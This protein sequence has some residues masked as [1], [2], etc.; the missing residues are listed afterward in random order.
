T[1]FS[2]AVDGNGRDALFAYPGGLAVDGSGNLYIADHNNHTI[3]KINAAGSVTTL[4][5]TAGIAGSADG[6]GSSARFN[7]PTGVAV[8]GSGNV[9]VADAGNQSIRKIAPSGAVTTFVG[10]SGVAGSSD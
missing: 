6:N 2:G 5:G 9:Y 7:G 4:A 8:D 1:G 3:R 10:F